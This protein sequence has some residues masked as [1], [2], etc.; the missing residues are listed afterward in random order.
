MTSKNEN[1]DMGKRKGIK[2][3]EKKRK[4]DGKMAR[5]GRVPVFKSGDVSSIPGPGEENQLLQVVL[6]SPWHKGILPYI[7]AYTK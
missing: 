1:I 3:L 7:Q 2:K 4:K 6:W 5:Q